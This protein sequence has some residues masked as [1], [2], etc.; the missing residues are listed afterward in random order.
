MVV[1]LMSESL[2]C[3]YYLCIFLPCA[4]ARQITAV[5]AV[6]DVSGR[7][8]VKTQSCSVNIGGVCML[9]DA[10]L[11]S[12]SRCRYSAIDLHGGASWLYN[13]FTGLFSGQ[14]KSGAEG[15]LQSGIVNAINSQAEQALA[16]L[17]ITAQV[18][19]L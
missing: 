3:L 5:V 6:G 17:P 18:F 15:A 9:S 19:S 16:T 1:T 14:I 12:V 8:S 13:L 7:P 2:L 11:R 10:V 4:H